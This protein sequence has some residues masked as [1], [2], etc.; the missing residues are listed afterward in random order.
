MTDAL[1]IIIPQVL[2]PA[3]L[4][5]RKTQHRVPMDPQPDPM[6]GA[7]DYGEPFTA[8]AK[9]LDVK[10]PYGKP[11]QRLWVQEEWGIAFGAKDYTGSD[12]DAFCYHADG[13]VR[14]FTDACKFLPEVEPFYDDCFYGGEW[15][16]AA[17]MPRWASRIS[18]E[19]EDVKAQRIQDICPEQVHMEGL[20][21]LRPEAHKDFKPGHWRSSHGAFGAHPDD[22]DPWGDF[23]EAED[24]AMVGDFQIYW[25][26]FNPAF[27]WASSWAW[28]ITFKR[29]ES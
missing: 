16:S 22:Q 4:D 9:E 27:P 26:H 14:A 28:A 18:L 15:E 5:G 1:P 21:S 11:G 12:P 17:D 2:I 19:V 20:V 23:C 10:G 6:A 25:D 24:A 29:I 13:R 3:L 7:F 8:S